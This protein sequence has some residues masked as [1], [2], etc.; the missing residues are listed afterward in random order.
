MMSYCVN[1]LCEDSKDARTEVYKINRK[2]MRHVYGL[3]IREV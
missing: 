1:G 2:L 3:E